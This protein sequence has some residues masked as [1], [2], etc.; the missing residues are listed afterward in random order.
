MTTVHASPTYQMAIETPAPAGYPTE[1]VDDVFTDA[2]DGSSFESRRRAFLDHCLLNP[3]P[4]NTKTIY[5]ELARVAA[6]GIAHEG[7]IAAALDYIDA[8]KDCSDFVMHGVLRM[9]YQFGG[10]EAEVGGQKPEVGNRRSE[11]GVGILE[12]GRQTVLDFKYWPDEPGIDSLCTWT[13]NHFIL[14][15]TAAYLAGQLYADTV[16]DNSGQTGREKM[17]INR[18]RILRWL[19]LRFH[20]GFSEWL[21]HVYYDE[22]LTALLSLIDFCEDEEIVRKATMVV[23]LLLLDM[24]LT[25]IAACSAA[26]MADPTK[27]RRNGRPARA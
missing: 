17:A 16:F 24:A 20:T 22:D 18:P 2:P 12:R 10:R 1:R 13:E 3:A 14:F 21:S 15:S 5:Y 23:D 25:A 9:L 8:R 27:T 19:D 26:R 6:G 11:V 4:N 7:T